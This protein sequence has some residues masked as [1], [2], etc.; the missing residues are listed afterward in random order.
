MFCVFLFF[1]IFFSILVPFGDFYCSHIS[2]MHIHPLGHTRVI[3]LTDTVTGQTWEP[4]LGPGQ[5]QLSS[6]PQRSRCWALQA[7]GNGRSLPSTAL[8]SALIVVLKGWNRQNRSFLLSSEAMLWCV[9]TSR[10]WSECW[11]G[12]LF[13]T[14]RYVV[15]Q[16]GVNCPWFWKRIR[17]WRFDVHIY[18]V[19]KSMSWQG[20][21]GV[22]IQQYGV[23]RSYI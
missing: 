4:L 20:F 16:E 6:Q 1:I 22:Y 3:S 8:Q 19:S 11:K 10:T 17:L 21:L 18:T 12:T 15:M 14:C 5:S 9:I 7:R 23:N 2:K 13:A